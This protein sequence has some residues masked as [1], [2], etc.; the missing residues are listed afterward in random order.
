MP[1][2]VYANNDITKVFYSGYTIDKIYACG[3]ELVYSAST[4]PPV[5]TGKLSYTISGNTYTI[6]C[7]STSA[8]TQY[9]IVSDIINKTGH[10][11]SIEST[12]IGNCVTTIGNN[13]F[14]QHT[15]LSSVT[16]PNSVTTIGGTAFYI[17]ESLS[18]VTIPSS[19]TSIGD[20][21]FNGS[22]LQS[23]TLPDSITVIPTSCFGNCIYLSTIDIPDSVTSIEYGA[24][25]FDNEPE[26]PETQWLAANRSVTIH[27]LTPPT[28]GELAFSWSGLPE[29][30]TY[31]IYVP[32]SSVEEY[33]AAWV[34]KLSNANT[35]IQ[36]IP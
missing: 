36:A 15:S 9:E 24:F 19:V 26:H 17:C 11:S 28:L 16:I 10:F 25:M 30:C 6:P 2:I 14:N 1:K 8:L 5:T 35:R 3:G 12:V 4:E 21:A 22:S 27:A 34:D 7:D 31:P 20:S 18:A 23:I 33:K 29:L 13:A 32:A